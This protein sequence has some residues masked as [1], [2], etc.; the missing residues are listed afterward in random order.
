MRS[1]CEA[2]GI[3]RLELNA[4][5]GRVLFA[6]EPAI[7]PG[8]LIMMIQ[9]ESTTYRFDGKRTL[10]ITREFGEPADAQAF[11][12]ALLD[13]LTPPGAVGGAESAERGANATNGKGGGSERHGGKGTSA[14]RRE[15]KSARR[16]DPATA[17]PPT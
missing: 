4:G 13:E 6:P 10:R 16:D 2:L 8:A 17:R 15:R 5:G 3:E 11:L 9:R 14:R 7:D 1:R 12:D